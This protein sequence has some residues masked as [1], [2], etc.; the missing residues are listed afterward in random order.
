ML[1][2]GAIRARGGRHVAVA[3]LHAIHPD[4]ENVELIEAPGLQLL[5]RQQPPA[6]PGG[7]LRQRLPIARADCRRTP[8]LSRLHDGILPGAPLPV[9]VG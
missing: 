7:K 2:P 6:S 5:Q 4:H 1:H 9:G 3:E 8:G